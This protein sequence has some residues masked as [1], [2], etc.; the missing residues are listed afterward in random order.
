MTEVAAKVGR[1]ELRRPG[2]TKTERR[3]GAQRE[4]NHGDRMAGRDTEGL[5]KWPLSH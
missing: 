2:A 1:I 5:D 4:L 3:E